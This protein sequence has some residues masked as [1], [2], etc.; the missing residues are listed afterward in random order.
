MRKTGII[1]FSILMIGS[2]VTASSAPLLPVSEYFAN[3]DFVVWGTI[4]DVDDVDESVVFPSGDTSVYAAKAIIQ[5]KKSWK[6]KITGDV[7]VYSPSTT[8]T[9]PTA[10]W[11]DYS[12]PFTEG[13]VVLLFGQVRE[14]GIYYTNS[15]QGSMYEGAVNY[16]ERLEYVN[17]QPQLLEPLVTDPVIDNTP[18]ADPTPNQEDVSDSGSLATDGQS[19]SIQGETENIED[20]APS[21]PKVETSEPLSPGEVE[22]GVTTQ[23]SDSMPTPAT[24]SPRPGIFE[25]IIAFFRNL[26]SFG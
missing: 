17:N 1:L 11:S 19:E 21:S 7:V 5:V 24:D 18:P 4:V 12:F 15:G 13:K 25:A 2:V 26:F 14:D 10:S 23:E 22:T 3:A 8:P 16:P 9:D 20:V 6:I